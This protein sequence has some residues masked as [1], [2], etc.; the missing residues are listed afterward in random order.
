MLWRK[1]QLLERVVGD[2]LHLSAFLWAVLAVIGSHASSSLF[3][4]CTHTYPSFSSPGVKQAHALWL[5]SNL[6]YFACSNWISPCWYVLNKNS[7]IIFLIIPPPPLPHFL[8]QNMHI[9]QGFCGYYIFHTTWPLNNEQLTGWA[10]QMA[11]V[12]LLPSAGKT[13]NHQ[14]SSRRLIVALKSGLCTLMFRCIHSYVN[15]AYANLS[16]N[17]IVLHCYIAFMKCL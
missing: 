5:K 17:N 4:G 10:G 12:T 1:H 9:T 15:S 14:Q 11:H 3:M 13:V 6:I 8:S 7:R 16:S 2:T